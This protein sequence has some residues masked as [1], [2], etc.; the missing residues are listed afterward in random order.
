[1]PRR[2]QVVA[3]ELPEFDFHVEACLQAIDREARADDEGTPVIN[4]GQTRKRVFR[5][6]RQPRARVV[7]TAMIAY[8]PRLPVKTQFIGDMQAR[9]P[10]LKLIGVTI[11]DVDKRD[12]MEREHKAIAR[13]LAEPGMLDRG[14]ERANIAR[15]L[16][17]SLHY[18]R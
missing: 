7:E 4:L 14:S 5:E 15:V 3:I 1:M 11:F 12:R 18:R 10:R 2:P 13:L 8:R 16:G 9:R 6:G 17:I